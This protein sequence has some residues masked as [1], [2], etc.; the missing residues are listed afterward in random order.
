MKNSTLWTF[1]AGFVTPAALVAIV[2]FRTPASDTNAEE[3]AAAS[4][5][6]VAAQ[7]SVDPTA[8]AGSRFLDRRAGER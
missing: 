4:S 8:A 2:A 5:K 6:A 7:E 3:D 1:V